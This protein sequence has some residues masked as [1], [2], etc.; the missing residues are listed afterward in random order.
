[1]SRYFD[2]VPSPPPPQNMAELKARL[3]LIMGFTLGEL[4][5]P[6]RLRVPQSSVHSKGWAGEFVELLLGARAQNLPLPDFVNLGIELKTMPI[7]RNF[8]PL[9]TTFLCHAPLYQV[10]GLNFEKS[11]LA[12]KTAAMLFVFIL[13]ERGM[14][15]AARRLIDYYLF[16]PSPAE[17][18]QIKADFDELM[19]LAAAGQTAQI[20]ARL[21]TII[22]LRPKCADGSQLVPCVDE[23]G[24]IS[25]TR[26][27]GFYLRRD[28]NKIICRRAAAG[29]TLPLPL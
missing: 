28:F 21:G 3:D 26:P 10:R 2:N 4:A 11:A 29:R 18:A 16:V 27:R 22:Q 9:E 14:P 15:P 7:D 8:E 1:M 24:Q 6:L 12:A 25:A 19:D 23:E 5:A 13:A 20:T 17:R